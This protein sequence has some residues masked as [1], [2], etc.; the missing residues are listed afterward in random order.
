MKTKQHTVG[1]VTEPTASPK[2]CGVGIGLDAARQ[3]RAEE[4][5][6]EAIIPKLLDELPAP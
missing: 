5:T 3:A 1:F 2:G 4:S 6:I